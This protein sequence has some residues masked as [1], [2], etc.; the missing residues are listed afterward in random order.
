MGVDVKV[1][2]GVFHTFDQVHKVLELKPYMR[3]RR[4]ERLV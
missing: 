4:G 2:R 3:G 1:V